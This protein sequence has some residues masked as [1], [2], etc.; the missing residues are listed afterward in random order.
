VE[1][2]VI[3]IILAFPAAILIWLLWIVVKG[4]IDQM[5]SQRR[6]RRARYCHCGYDL[7]ET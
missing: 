5:P 6:K 2:L 1:D 7:T 3:L 4:F